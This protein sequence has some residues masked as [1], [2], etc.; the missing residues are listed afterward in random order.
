MVNIDNIKEDLKIKLKPS[1]YKHTI[2]VVNKAV[3]LG[4]IFKIDREKCYLAAL[5]HDCAKGN[6]EF[7]KE[8]YELEY[9]KL[10]D[11]K[12][13]KEYDNKF[14]QHCLLGYI[15]AK[16]LYEIR[17]KEILDAILFH[18]TGREDMTDLEKI[19]Y[20]ADKTEDGRDYPEVEI[21]RKE[22][23]LNLNNAIIISINNNIKY[24]IDKNQIISINS[25][26][27]RN[28]LLGGISE[29]KIGFNS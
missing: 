17:D 13:L 21:I 24:L 7:Y 27:L 15:V 8:K 22:S 16:N 1:R 10:I 25:I 11:E 2:R 26:K 14:L 28:G 12:K 5:L 29:G 6:E 19:V 20:L 9:F 4:D 18:T 3:E 23:F